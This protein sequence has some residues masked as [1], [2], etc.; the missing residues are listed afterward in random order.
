MEGEI[1]R[2]TGA[3]STVLQTLFV[4]CEEEGAELKPKLSVYW[5]A[6]VSTLSYAQTG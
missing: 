2:Q 6:Y 3:V 4:C 5:S 1:D